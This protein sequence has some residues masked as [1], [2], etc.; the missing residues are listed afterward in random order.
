MGKAE[1]NLHGGNR[2]AAEGRGIRGTEFCNKK[3]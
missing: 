3:E 1:I 2:I